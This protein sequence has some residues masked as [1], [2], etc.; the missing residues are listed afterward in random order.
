MPLDPRCF[1]VVKKRLW[2]GPD[3]VEDGFEVSY[4]KDQYGKLDEYIFDED[5]GSNLVSNWV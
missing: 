2:F 3:S 1:S 5:N 4:K